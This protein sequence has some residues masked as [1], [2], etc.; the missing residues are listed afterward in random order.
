MCTSRETTVYLLLFLMSKDSEVKN[1]VNFLH[2]PLD[3]WGMMRFH[4]LDG[5]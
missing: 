5:H 1:D 4:N 3:D 2:R